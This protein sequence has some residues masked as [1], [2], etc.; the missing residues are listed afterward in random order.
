[1][2]NRYYVCD[3]CDHSFMVEQKMDAHLKKKCPECGERK[4]YQDLSG[5]HTFVYQDCKTLGHQAQRNTDRM[6]KLDLEMRRERDS[7]VAK[8]KQRS[9]STWYNKDGSDL[10]NELARLGEGDRDAVAA[11]KHKYIMEGK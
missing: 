3:E 2:V 9:K 6:G 8:A 5:Q 11:K 4:L 7:K 10:K 1:M